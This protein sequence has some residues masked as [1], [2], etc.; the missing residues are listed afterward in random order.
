MSQGN[1][2]EVRFTG[3]MRASGNS[4]AP[5]I[6]GYA[7]TYN[8]QTELM[9]GLF[10]VI[11]PGAFTRTLAEKADVRCLFNHN[12]DII[13]GRT[14]S[15]TL[16]LREDGTG[17]FFECDVPKS[18]M[19]VYESVQRGDVSECSFGFTVADEHFTP[20][21]KTDTLR[22]LLDVDLFDVSVVVFPAY[23]STSAEAR[24]L[25]PEGR[26]EHLEARNIARTVRN[27]SKAATEDAALRDSA[28]RRAQ[29]V[30][31][32][33]AAEEIERQRKMLNAA[34]L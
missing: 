24:N 16:R 7:A 8:S 31:D 32:E 14:K 34:I 9:S 2:R 1:K 4:T 26:P 29:S 23:G 19:D 18:R 6:A 27:H 15:K 13:L 20:S 3:R 25:W 33:I 17:L 22:E 21:G 10:E 11:R 12:E 5:V 28:R 30:L